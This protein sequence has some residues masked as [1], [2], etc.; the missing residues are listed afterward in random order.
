LDTSF[1]NTLKFEEIFSNNDFA[2]FG[3]S[4]VNF[5]YNAAIFK[6]TSKLQ[7][8]KVWDS[9]LADACKK[10]P[11]RS[12]VGSR[13]NKGELGDVVEAFIGYVYLTNK[14]QINQLIDLLT[15][16]LKHRIDQEVKNEQ[17]LCSAAFVYLVNQLC[18]KLGIEEKIS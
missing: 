11:L 15:Q 6:A 5:I 4:V 10:S 2:K 14:F 7:G 8:V 13:K 18:D 1:T 9:C 16:H 3:D 17:E 12:Y